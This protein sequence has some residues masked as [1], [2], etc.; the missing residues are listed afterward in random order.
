MVGKYNDKIMKT[1]LLKHLRKCICHRCCN[2]RCV[3]TWMC[4]MI[5]LLSVIV[6]FVEGDWTEGMAWSC[7]TM[8]WVCVLLDE[9]DNE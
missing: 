5:C 1:R 9:I 8:A 2:G 7:A 3:L 4:V 6:N